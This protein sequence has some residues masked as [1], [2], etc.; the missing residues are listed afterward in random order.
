MKC[1]RC[2]QILVVDKV[3]EFH[4]IGGFR[5]YS[6]K[7]RCE[8]GWYSCHDGDDGTDIPES[9]KL[10]AKERENQRSKRSP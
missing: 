10:A 8:C 7:V 4:N 9:M 1:G 5:G 6:Y 3:Y 2:G